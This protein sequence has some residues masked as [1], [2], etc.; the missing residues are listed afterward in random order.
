MFIKKELDGKS[1]LYTEE[2]IFKVWIGRYIKGSYRLKFSFK[3]NFNQALHYYNCLNIG[4]GYKKKLTMNDITL[5]KA[6][7]F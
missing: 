3:G 4:N 6:R 7:S 2:T 5:A 1:I